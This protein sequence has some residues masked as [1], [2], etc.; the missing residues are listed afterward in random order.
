MG[1]TLRLLEAQA[2]E[3]TH[4]N[5]HGHLQYSN[6]IVKKTKIKK[7]VFGIDPSIVIKREKSKDGVPKIIKILIEEIKKKGKLKKK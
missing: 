6:S 3:N 7:K 1:N 4:L 2:T 5:R